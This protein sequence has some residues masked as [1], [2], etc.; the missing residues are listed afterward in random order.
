MFIHFQIRCAVVTRRLKDRNAICFKAAM[1]I[2]YM[3]ALESSFV[4]YKMNKQY[5]IPNI[6]YLLNN[7][8]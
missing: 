3:T 5:E 2:T 7:S 1:S 4:V 6:Q 8:L